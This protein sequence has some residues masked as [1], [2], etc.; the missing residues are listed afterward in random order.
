MFHHAVEAE[1]DGAD[2]YL[3]QR[4]Q[5][6]NGVKIINLEVDDGGPRAEGRDK[7]RWQSSAMAVTQAYGTLKRSHLSA[8]TLTRRDHEICSPSIAQRK[9]NDDIN[10]FPRATGQEKWHLR[11]GVFLKSV[12]ENLLL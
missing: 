4:E 10:L 8:T 7:T 9:S 12:Q 5:H 3:Y 2:T 11:R 6:T 1:I